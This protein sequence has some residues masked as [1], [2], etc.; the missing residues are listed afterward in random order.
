MT[1][2]PYNLRA[3][4]VRAVLDGRL[5]LLVVPLKPRGPV[6]LIDGTWTDDY[7][8]DPGNADWLAQSHKFSPGDTLWCREAWKTNAELN[9]LS[10]LEIA[11]KHDP[12]IWYFADG[13]LK[14]WRDCPPNI[15][16]HRQA[17]HMPRWASRIS[18][19]VKGVTVKRVQDV[20][21]EEAIA[22]DSP[23]LIYSDDGKFHEHSGGSVRVG[24]MG[25][26][27][28]RHG[29]DAWDRGDWCAFVEVERV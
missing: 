19:T 24:F 23:R 13:D 7:V 14:S 20:T 6:S 8:L 15:G 10:P 3:H 29:P 1:D 5:T 27:V 12:S 17:M 21:E 9:S 11:A 25:A 26:F 4:E 22:A 2:R 28:H 18:L 16:R